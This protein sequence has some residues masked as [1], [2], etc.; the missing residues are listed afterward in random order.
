M[1]NTTALLTSKPSSAAALLVT[2]GGKSMTLAEAIVR[3][4]AMKG[5]AA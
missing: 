3:L 4:E 5:I 1:Q 2:L